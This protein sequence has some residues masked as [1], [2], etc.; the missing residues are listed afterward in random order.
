MSVNEL[1]S[2]SIGNVSICLHTYLTQTYTHYGAL[3]FDAEEIEDISQG[4]ASTPQ[5]TLHIAV[6]ISNKRPVI[7]VADVLQMELYIT[8]GFHTDCLTWN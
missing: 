6:L 8:G 7:P 2:V 1:G 3:K 4:R 5:L